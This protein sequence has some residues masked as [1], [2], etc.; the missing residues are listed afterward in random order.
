MINEYKLFKMALLR[1]ERADYNRKVWEVTA[2]DAGCL[3]T[4]SHGCVK[5]IYYGENSDYATKIQLHFNANDEL[6]YAE[7]WGE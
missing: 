1:I 2:K 4:E 7:G 6:V 3:N 5:H